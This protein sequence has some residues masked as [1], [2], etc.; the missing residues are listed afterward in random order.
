M[1]TLVYTE[2]GSTK[3]FPLP[4][5]DTVVGRATSCDLVIND[6]RVS[7]KH[8]RFSVADTQCIVTDIGSLN[9]IFRQGEPIASAAV[10]DGDVVVLG[11]LPVRIERSVADQLDFSDHRIDLAGTIVRS[12]SE[13]SVSTSTVSE[14]ADGKGLLQLLSNIAGTLV[15][16][17]PLSDALERVV[18]LTFGTIAAERAILILTSATG[19]LVP[20]VV[21]C[22]DQTTQA[23]ATISRTIVN[24]VLSERVAILASDAQ[25]DAKLQE[26]ESIRGLAIRSFMCAPLWA[27]HEVIGA[28]YV[29]TPQTRRFSAADLD[30]FTALANYAAVAIEQARLHER[31]LEETRRRERLQRYHSP[32][33]VDR[34]LQ[35][36]DEADA[37]FI[38]QERDLTVLFADIVGFTGL[39]EAM[40]SAQISQLLN[41]YLG[42]MTN[43]IF[44]QEG[45]LDKFIGDAVM[46]VFGAPLD[47]ADHALRAVRAAQQMREAVGGLNVGRESP[48]EL[49]I[50]INSG[51]ALAGDMG[52]PKRREYTVLGDVVNTASRLQAITPPGGI[53][54]SRA[55]FDRL[56][57]RLAARSRGTVSLRGRVAEVEIFE[58]PD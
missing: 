27:Q 20:R 45:T 30:L 53:L 48:I 44:Q 40:S 13:T 35:T 19:E 50:A 26:A 56:N 31:L 9:G 43:I 18:D 41:T 8:A 25:L 39:A 58:V 16:P 34:I 49:R 14:V 6:A 36:G 22:R 46:A 55:T 4:Q 51:M 11:R 38:A 2:G 15:T 52:S 5:G 24:R 10:N 1:F 29:D 37:P 47:Q 21:R 42:C 28:L 17:Q 57:G 32:S 3:R 7:R 12:V 54:I 33:V 23:S